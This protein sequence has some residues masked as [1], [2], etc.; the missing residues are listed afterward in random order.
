MLTIVGKSGI[1]Y[2]FT[3]SRKKI[4]KLFYFLILIK[5]STEQAWSKL[6]CDIYSLKT[7]FY[8]WITIYVNLN[9]MFGQSFNF[10]LIL[11]WWFAKN[12]LGLVT[13]LVTLEICTGKP[14]QMVAFLFRYCENKIEQP[15]KTVRKTWLKTCQVL[16]RLIQELSGLGQ[17]LS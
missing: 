15:L 4:L 17:D 8:Q 11:Y 1:I 3:N 12:C 7:Y 10:F 2:A 13:S 6:G 5:I 14:F 9:G 16:P